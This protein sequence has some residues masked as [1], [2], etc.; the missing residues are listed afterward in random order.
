[1]FSARYASITR[2]HLKVVYIAAA[3]NDD[4]VAMS[5]ISKR[6]DILAN[7]LE[8]NEVGRILAKGAGTHSLIRKKYLVQ[9]YNLGKY[10]K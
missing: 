4:E 6:F 5:V 8:M 7:Y 2:K 1:M 10:L 9:A 3:W